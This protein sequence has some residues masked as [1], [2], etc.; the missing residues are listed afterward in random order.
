M[1]MIVGHNYF[2]LNLSL[3]SILNW[4]CKA[5][6]TNFSANDRPS[7]SSITESA[8]DLVPKRERPKDWLSNSFIL[9][10]WL[11]SLMDKK[12]SL[13]EYIFMILWKLTLLQ[14]CFR[15][16]LRLLFIISGSSRVFTYLAPKM[17]FV[18]KL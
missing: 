7:I 18:S 14:N 13:H 10:L 9:I 4:I 1:R 15:I 8:E 5:V 6:Y 2:L 17:F 3:N 16:F 12:L 11:K